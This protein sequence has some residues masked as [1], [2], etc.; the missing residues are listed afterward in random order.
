MIIS[1]LLLMGSFSLLAVNINNIIADL[2]AQNQVIAYINESL[3]DEEAKSLEDSLL[4]VGNVVSVSFITR[5]QA[6]DSFLIQFE[7]N[8]IFEDID[9]SV[10]RNRFIVNMGD[11]SL[12]ETTSQNLA[13]IPGIAWVSAPLR[14]Q[15]ALLWS[16][17]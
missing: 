7:D 16:E 1:C 6:M 11:I 8:R 2:E 3:T 13:N 17:A 9:A 12:M 5:E 10:F 4:D 15:E 14:F